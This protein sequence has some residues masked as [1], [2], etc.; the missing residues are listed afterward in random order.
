V[1]VL[2]L[3]SPP[4]AHAGQMLQAA[5]AGKHIIIEKPLTGYFGPSEPP[6]LPGEGAGGGEWPRGAATSPP[7]GPCS[8]PSWTR[9]RSSRLRS[10]RPG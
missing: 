6:P 3:L 5:A 9:S 1:D 8:R 4:S 10:P 7:S 2:D